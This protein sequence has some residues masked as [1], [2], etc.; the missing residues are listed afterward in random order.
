MT[1]RPGRAGL[2][3]D[4]WHAFGAVEL[5]AIMAS[6]SRGARGDWTF[7]RRGVAIMAT[8]ATRFMVRSDAFT[9]DITP[10]DRL[11]ARGANLQHHRRERKPRNRA[12]SGHR[13]Q[14]AVADQ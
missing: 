5:G 9:R 10:A 2:C 3:A 6:L 8:L 1:R 11:I 4:Q 12:A 14:A 13:D 7:T